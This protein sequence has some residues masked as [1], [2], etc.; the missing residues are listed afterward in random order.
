MHFSA[1]TSVVILSFK[2]TCGWNDHL[3]EC[4]GEFRFNLGRKYAVKNS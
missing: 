1:L 3:D 2:P 4:E